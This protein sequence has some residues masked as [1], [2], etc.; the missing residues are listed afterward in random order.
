MPSRTAPPLTFRSQWRAGSSKVAASES[1]GVEAATS[2]GLC[3]Y[4]FV[5]KKLAAKRSADRTTQV[6]TLL[7]KESTHNNTIIIFEEV[8]GDNVDVQEVKIV[9]MSMQ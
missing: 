6:C 3:Y 1:E 5:N 4:L 7:A 9:E 2:A 8:G